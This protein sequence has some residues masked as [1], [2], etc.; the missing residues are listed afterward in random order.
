MKIRELN[1]S[2][3][4]GMSVY[5]IVILSLALTALSLLLETYVDIL[6]GVV[7]LMVLLGNT[8]LLCLIFLPKVNFLLLLLR[9]SVCLSSDLR[10]V[11]FL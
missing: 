2:K 6:Y 3:L 1:D 4:I 11:A 10:T 7:G 5:C 8:F 9:P